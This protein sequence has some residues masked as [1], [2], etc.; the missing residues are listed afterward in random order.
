[1]TDSAESRTIS[2]AGGPVSGLL[3]RPANARAVLVLGHGAGAG[4]RH[5]FMEAVSQRLATR[6]LATF[7][8]QFPYMEKGVSR[9]D[10]PA[11]ATA[12]VRAVCEAARAELP[13]LPL[14]AGGKSFGGRMTSTAQSETPLPGVRGLVFLGFPLH[15]PN[16]PSVNRAEHLGLVRIPMLFLQGTRDDLAY[17]DLIRDVTGKLGALATLHVVQEGDHSFSVLKRSGR[18]PDQVLDELALATDEWF[19]GLP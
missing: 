4:M 14:L 11:V 17:L 9:T 5:P 16:R 8:Y 19:A 2:T 6:R 7:R 3:L 1:M 18:N 12:T 15:P 10:S 13:E